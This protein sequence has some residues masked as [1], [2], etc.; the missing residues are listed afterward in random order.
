MFAI[1]SVMFWTS[2]VHKEGLIL[3]AIGFFFYAAHK[4]SIKPFKLKYFFIMLLSAFALWIIRDFIFYLLLPGALAY[5]FIQIDR[6]WMFSKFI[7]AYLIT[8]FIGLTFEFTLREKGE[9]YK[10]NV[11]QSIS[12]KQRF[13]ET[14]K[15]GN[16]AIDIDDFQPELIFA[17][18]EA[19]KA[20][21]RTLC[22][23]FY[24]TSFN[25]YQMVFVVE[26]V[27]ILLLI[28]Y[29]LYNTSLKSYQ[30]HPLSVWYFLFAVS[31]MVLIGIVVSNIGAS[32][33]YRSVPLLL[34]ILSLLPNLKTKYNL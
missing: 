16:T 34:L 25:M 5:L 33:R 19:P 13:F 30:F 3:S 22:I 4:L 1:P 23:P 6:R 32:L 24:L 17:F 31:L 18:K 12:L 15:G 28:G 29:L 2:G 10:A 27:F 21:F 7:A 9:V 11:M 26:N 14:L 8:L 20:F